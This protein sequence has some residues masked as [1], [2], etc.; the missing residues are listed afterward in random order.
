MP[1]ILIV[2]DNSENRELLAEILRDMATCDFAE[3]GTEAIRTYNR[4]VEQNT[5]FDLILLDLELPEMSGLSILERIR[6][7]ERQAGIRLAEGVP[8]VVVTGYQRRFLEAFNKGCDDYL[9]K[10]IDAGSLIAKVTQI[11]SRR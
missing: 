6:E 9:L 5:P 10:P 11:L 1:R 7:S 2:E 3:T 4:S 8:V